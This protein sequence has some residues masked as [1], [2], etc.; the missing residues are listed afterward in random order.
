MYYF[1]PKYLMSTY[2]VP[3]T[4]QVVSLLIEKALIVPL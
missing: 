2:D 4:V 3:D 1:I